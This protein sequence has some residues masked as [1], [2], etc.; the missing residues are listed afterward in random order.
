[1]NL[2]CVALLSFSILIIAQQIV[3]LELSSETFYDEV[4]KKPSFVKFYAPWCG[5]CK[6]LAPVWTALAEELA[7]K[8]EIAKVD[9]TS[10]SSVKLCQA[11][12]I[13]SFPTLIYIKD[14]KIQKHEGARDKESLKTFVENAQPADRLPTLHKPQ[15]H[16]SSNSKVKS[17]KDENASDVLEGVWIVDLYKDTCPFCQDL[18]PEWEQLAKLVDGKVNVAKANIQDSKLLFR[19]SEVRGVPSIRLFKDGR[20]YNTT[21]RGQKA[22]EFVKWIEEG[23]KTEANYDMP[24]FLR[25]GQRQATAEPTSQ[26]FT[27]QFVANQEA[28]L[29]G[30]AGLL[31][32]ALGVLVGRMT[33]PSEPAQQTAQKSKPTKKEM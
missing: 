1:M 28:L 19:A 4:L 10:E 33:A 24:Q 22:S 9:C 16:W 13:Q 15:L 6:S 25:D 20:I 26:H 7:G 2:R 12:G 11:F 29:G 17:I 31:L 18:I 3:P 8:V 27:D 14:G 21:Y 23:Y 30:L 32:F 5:F